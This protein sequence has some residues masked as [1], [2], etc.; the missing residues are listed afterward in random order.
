[1]ILNSSE[2]NPLKEIFDIMPPMGQ[3]PT[4]EILD[5]IQRLLY[6]GG[7]VPEDADEFFKT[8]KLLREVEREY[9]GKR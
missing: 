2:F 8:Y 9:N 5:N 7:V 3:E 4:V 1:M 6:Q